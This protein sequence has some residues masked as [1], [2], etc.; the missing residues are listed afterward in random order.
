MTTIGVIQARFDSSRLP[1]KVLEHVGATTMLAGV[2]RRLSESRLVDEVVVATTTSPTDDGIAALVANEGYEVVRGSSFDVLDR[3]HDV[4]LARPDADVVVRVTADCPFLDP[5]LVD[6][7]IRARAEHGVDFASNRLPPPY[8]RTYPVGLDVEVSTSAALR[9]AWSEAD[10]PYFREHV[11]PF[12][13]VEDSQFSRFIVDLDADYSQYRWTVDT[14]EDLRAA[15]AIARYLPHSSTSWRDV[16][17]VVV[18]HPELVAINA[19]FTQKQVTQVD[20]RWT[21][22]DRKRD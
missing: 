11:M 3:F 13:Y 20:S 4:L 19:Q 10:E 5:E 9:R 2:M 16:L 18:E 8:A 17:A 14:P 6:E 1:G 22:I 12:L 15:R 21:E 7:V